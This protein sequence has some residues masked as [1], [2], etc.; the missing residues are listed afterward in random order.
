MR[1]LLAEPRVGNVSRT[2]GNRCG[3]AGVSNNGVDGCW[4]RSGVDDDID[5]AASASGGV[6]GGVKFS[7]KRITG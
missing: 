2:M 6:A 3:A 1:G 5:V 4:S 7:V